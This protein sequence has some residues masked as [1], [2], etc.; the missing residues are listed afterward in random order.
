[1]EFQHSLV[2]VLDINSIISVIGEKW[3]N[4]VPSFTDASFAIPLN[5]RSTIMPIRMRLKLC[6]GKNHTMPKY[7]FCDYDMLELLPKIV[8]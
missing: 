5:I 7:G 3:I 6:S 8:M 2:E 4:H 1:M